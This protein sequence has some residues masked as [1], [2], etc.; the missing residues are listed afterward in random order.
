[1]L[2]PVGPKHHAIAPSTKVLET[3]KAFEASFIKEMLSATDLGKAGDGSQDEFRTLLLDAYAERIVD[4]G[5]FGLA[6]AIMHSL[7]DRTE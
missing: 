1:M 3:A 5:G 4:K 6:Q 7:E 2:T